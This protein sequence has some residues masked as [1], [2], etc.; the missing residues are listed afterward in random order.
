MLKASQPLLAGGGADAATAAVELATNDN[1]TA[2][3]AMKRA[4]R[5]MNPVPPD[6]SYPYSI[7]E[8]RPS[9][10]YPMSGTAGR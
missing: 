6:W 3:D 5:R 1:E 9:A 7:P 10:P 4:D 8:R 2:A